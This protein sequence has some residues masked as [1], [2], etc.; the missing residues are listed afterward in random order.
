MAS[1]PARAP[2]P[3]DAAGER[4]VTEHL[5]L[6][7][8]LARRYQGRG[9]PLDDLEQVAMVGLINA[10]RRFDPTRE[11]SFASFARPTILGELR[12]H[13]RDRTWSV[14]M[15][16]AL[17]ESSR[18]ISRAVDVLRGNLGRS[19][20]VAELAEYTRRTDDEVLDALVA[21]SAYRADSL[22]ATP[23]EGDKPLEAALGDVDSGFARAED[24]ATVSGSLG[25][26]PARERAILDL[27]FREGLT[28]SEIADRLGI[29][30]MHVSRLIRRSLRVLREEID[31]EPN[32]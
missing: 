22:S 17:Q 4:L 30:Q 24:R 27:R 31:T 28:Q 9:E 13:F 8:A 32:P 29:S 1:E 15:P 25:V 12:R 21:G 11:T 10:A 26:L 18:E 5:Q 3:M 23:G 20:S 14:R 16:R 6:A 2:A 19:P 7:R